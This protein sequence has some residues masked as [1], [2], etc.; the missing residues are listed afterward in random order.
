MGEMKKIK[1]VFLVVNLKK[2]GAAKVAGQMAAYLHERGIAVRDFRFRG[3]PQDPVVPED[4]DLAVSLG[5][6]G[7]V[8]YTARLLSAA[9]IPILAVNL[10]SIGFITEVARD[11]W[12]TALEEYESGRLGIS[13]RLLLKVTLEREGQ[14]IASYYGLNDAVISASGISKLVK[15][16]VSLGPTSL[17]QY[18]A[19]GVVV[20]TPTGSTA[21]S[22][23]AGGPILYPEMEALVL[24]PICPFSLSN[25]PVVISSR[26]T[27]QVLVEPEQ[28]SEIN[29]TVDG[30][31][32]HDLKKRDVVRI[33]RSPFSVPII[34]SNRRT[35]YEVVRSK[36]NWTGG[37]NA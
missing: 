24:T 29:L 36:L 28:R 7:T 12:K 19:D 14:C 16:E 1:S 3:R 32:T 35:F 18:R 17:G 2:E 37:P 10:G 34:R 23:A 30:Q 11:E 6:D 9:A 8:L 31:N 5:G 33:C 22:L 26:E 27:V 20:A 21:Y 13:E 4:C 15:L 25:R